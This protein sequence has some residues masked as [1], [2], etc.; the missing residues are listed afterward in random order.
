MIRSIFFN[1]FEQQIITGFPIKEISEDEVLLIGA[2]HQSI[3]KYPHRLS[4][5][6]GLNMTKWDSNFLFQ[7][8]NI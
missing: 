1:C 6:Q 7:S 5:G 2:N 8:K 4:L 3:G